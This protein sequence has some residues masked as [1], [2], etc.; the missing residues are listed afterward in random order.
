[1]SARG[2]SLS[3]E[4]LASRLL[5]PGQVGRAFFG[6]SA[7]EERLHVDLMIVLPGYEE[8]ALARSSERTLLGARFTVA[9][10][11]DLLLS[12][13]VSGRPQDCADAEAIV[14]RGGR[15]LDASYVRKWASELAG[16]LARP[17][18]TERVEQFLA[19]AGPQA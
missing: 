7:S 19:R 10:A 2:F 5:S 15:T 13:I 12:K 16:A 4:D 17:D 11:E 3:E 9:S 18:L 8:Q 6:G 1:M 14:A